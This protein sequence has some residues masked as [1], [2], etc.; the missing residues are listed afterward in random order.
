MLET[1][2]R[3]PDRQAADQTFMRYCDLLRAALQ[4]LPVRYRLVAQGSYANRTNVAL[5]PELRAALR[6]IDESPELPRG[7]IDIV[8]EIADPAFHVEGAF[9]HEVAAYR[10]WHGLR[11]HLSAALKRMDPGSRI[12]SGPRAIRIVPPNGDFEVDIIVALRCADRPGTLVFW[13]V[14]DNSAI[15]DTVRVLAYPEAHRQAIDDG[16]VQLRRQF[17]PLARALKAAT[18]YAR[19]YP[20]R[21]QR[22]R[23]TGGMIDPH[24]FT[25]LRSQYTAGWHL[26]SLLHNLG[27]EVIH[28]RIPAAFDRVVRFIHRLEYADFARLDLQPIVGHAEEDPDWQAW[29]AAPLYLLMFELAC[30]R[31]ARA[32]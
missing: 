13:T 1:W 5:G 31:T 8:V 25:G 2:S 17:R 3:A 27:P 30:Q 6:R 16:D 11:E 7:D 14:P 4:Y 29:R 10:R 21:E 32:W 24:K 28:G 20:C 22:R 23:P 12:T 9:G 26:E 18:A 19:A 15:E